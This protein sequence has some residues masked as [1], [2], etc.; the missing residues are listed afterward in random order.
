MSTNFLYAQAP[1][2]KGNISKN[3]AE[4]TAV[5]GGTNKLMTP[6]GSQGN[7]KSL[8]AHGQ[9]NQAAMK[10]PVKLFTP[11]QYCGKIENDGYLKNSSF[12]K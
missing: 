11:K 2:R 9:N 12:I 3:P 5:T 7:T 4:H 6:K 10:Q 1:N 8:D